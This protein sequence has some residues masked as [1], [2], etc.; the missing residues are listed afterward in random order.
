MELRILL[1]LSQDIPDFCLLE[2]ETPRCNQPALPECT[3]LES[4]DMQQGHQCAKTQPYEQ[5]VNVIGWSS[6]ISSNKSSFSP[7]RHHSLC[8]EVSISAQPVQLPA[9][10]LEARACW[11]ASGSALQTGPRTEVGVLSHLLRSGPELDTGAFTAGA[12][13]DLRHSF[14]FTFSSADYEHN[15]LFLPR[16]LPSDAFFNFK[17]RWKHNVKD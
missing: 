9:F 4:C 17:R 2:V 1:S 7:W 8:R 14:F 12:L 11:E 10:L 16:P 13:A 15:N 3:R 5:T 6:H